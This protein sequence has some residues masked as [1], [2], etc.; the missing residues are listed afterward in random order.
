MQA[1]TPEIRDLARRLLAM[2]AANHG[3]SEQHLLEAARLCATLQA[4]LERF[5][6]P[7]GF[8][9]LLRRALGLARAEVPSLE[10]ATV[11]HDGQLQGVE[12]Y[13]PGSTQGQTQNENQAAVTIVAY[14]LWLLITFIGEPQ[15]MRLVRDAWPEAVTIA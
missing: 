10:G 4:S 11:T 13:S 2:E 15:T 9:A 6:G 8:N 5:A 14:L 12:L 3:G 7:D 1:P